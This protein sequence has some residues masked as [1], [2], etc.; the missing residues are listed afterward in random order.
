M[1]YFRVRERSLRVCTLLLASAIALSAQSRIQPGTL[2]S[3][4]REDDFPLA[5]PVEAAVP[6]T[7]ALDLSGKFD[8][9]VKSIS[10]PEVIGRMTLTTAI[11][12]SQEGRSYMQ[13]FAGRYA[14][15]LTRRT[16][17]FGIGAV[18]GEDPRFRRSGK[19][20]FLART[21]FVLSR[22]VLTDMDNGTTSIAAGRL[23]GSFAGNTLSAYWHPSRPDP[24]KHGLTGMGV[25]LAGDLG[26]RM[27]REFWPDIKH[28]FKK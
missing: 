21:G 16:V 17:Q 13:T 4:L 1:Q 23:V 25:N 9:Y 14:E 2:P 6:G 22:T 10:S 27:M 11:G 26:W 5:T 24:L 19:E 8:Y 12:G 7:P 3:D 28:K 20:G 18:R 15:T